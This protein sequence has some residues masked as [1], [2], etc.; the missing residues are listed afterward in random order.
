MYALAQLCPAAA[1][2]PAV[3]TGR[4]CSPVRPNAKVKS[5]DKLVIE[6][7]LKP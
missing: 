4:V 2:V 3:L 7:I 6:G 1:A 5:P